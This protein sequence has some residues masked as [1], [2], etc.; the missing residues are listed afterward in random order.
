MKPARLHPSAWLGLLPLVFLLVV[1]LAP[2][3]RI[4]VEAASGATG[5]MVAD[6]WRD[7]YLR[8]RIG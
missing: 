5:A 1:M 2:L 8:W 4:G 7:D 3:L 6:L